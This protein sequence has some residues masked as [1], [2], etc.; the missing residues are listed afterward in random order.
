MGNGISLF[1]ASNICL[2]MLWQILSPIRI[3]TSSGIQFDG[4]IIALFHLL[5]TRKSLLFA[6]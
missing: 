2:N 1:I 4:C 6:S 3:D 5:L